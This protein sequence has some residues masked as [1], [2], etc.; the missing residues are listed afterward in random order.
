MRRV[1]VFLKR[2]VSAHTELVEVFLRHSRRTA[3]ALLG[4]PFD[5]LSGAVE[6]IIVSEGEGG[7]LDLTIE[8]PISHA[9]FGERIS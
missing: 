5:T 6:K 2:S 3:G 7:P 1:F 9:S 8:R 4:K